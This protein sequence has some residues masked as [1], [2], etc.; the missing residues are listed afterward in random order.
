MEQ[1]QLF[2]DDLSMFSLVFYSYVIFFRGSSEFTAQVFYF[3]QESEFPSIGQ[4]WI[5]SG[6]R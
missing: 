4:S 2:I 1:K 6:K 5:P 3:S